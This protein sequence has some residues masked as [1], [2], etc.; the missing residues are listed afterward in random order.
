MTTNR[1]LLNETASAMDVVKRA[2]HDADRAS[3]GAAVSE[4]ATLRA[5]IGIGGLASWGS[6][7]SPF[8]FRIAARPG[9]RP[10]LT[11]RPKDRGGI[12]VR[13]FLNP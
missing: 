13:P 12:G 7:I 3:D 9:R 11:C 8:G 5:R 4:I 6:T 2:L 10:C 1:E